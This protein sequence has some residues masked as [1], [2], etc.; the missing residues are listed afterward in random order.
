[1]TID[2]ASAQPR[3]IEASPAVLQSV[4]EPQSQ[5]TR[6]GTG[7]PPDGS[8]AHEHQCDRIQPCTACSLHQIPECCQ[9]DLSESE[10]KPI[11]QAEALKKKDKEI[12]NLRHQIQSLGS[13]PIKV[14]YPDEDSSVLDGQRRERPPQIPRK[15][16][17][18]QQLRMHRGNPED[19]IYYGTPALAN[20]IEEVGRL[21]P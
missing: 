5:G 2:A 13:Q 4:Q 20:V 17:N 1:M 18:L 6:G 3:E 19:N 8:S 16:S 7:A 21:V 9:Y 15:P 10:R 11:L 14:E 12:A